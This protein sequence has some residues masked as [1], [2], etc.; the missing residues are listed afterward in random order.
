[1]DERLKA[2]ERLL[3]IM[4][5]L[6]AQCPWDQK[7]TFETLRNL[8]IEETFELADAI[9]KN[10]LQEIKGE[11]GD[12]FLH[13]VF[14]SKLGSEVGAFD[15]GDVLNAICDKLVHRHPHIY[16]DVQ[17]SGEEEVKANWEKLKLKEGKKSVLSGVPSS[18][19]ALVKATRIQEKAK[20]IGFEWDTKEDV[21]AKVKE[22]LAEFEAEVKLGSNKQEE[23]FGDLLFSL[24]NYAR[25]INLSPESALS[26]TNQKF[27]TRF[28]WMEEAVANDGKALSD[29]TLE[30]MDVYWERAKQEL[31]RMNA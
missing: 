4:D 12:L 21:W 10:D 1:M 11:I 29:M 20:G 6:R 23:E 19:P 8:T 16:G 25:F 13:M 18:L 3:T 22:E 17:V 30:E 9:T 7:Q 24:V 15:V 27:I 26:I 2:F 14:Y 5:E 28:Q 31:K